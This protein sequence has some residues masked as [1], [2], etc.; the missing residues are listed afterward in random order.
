MRARKDV[1]YIGVTVRLGLGLG[2]SVIGLELS[3]RVHVIG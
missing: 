2:F 3:A 1:W